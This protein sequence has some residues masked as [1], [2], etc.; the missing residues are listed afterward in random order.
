MDFLV[1]THIEFLYD[2][3]N[4]CEFVL[5]E[6]RK[7]LPGVKELQVAERLKGGF[8]SD[9]TR[10]QEPLLGLVDRLEF[11]AGSAVPTDLIQCAF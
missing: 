3:P 9:N 10:L 8:G 11:G 6:Q 4:G 1:I 5:D 7:P 2:G